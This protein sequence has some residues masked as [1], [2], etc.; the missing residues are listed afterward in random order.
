MIKDELK[1]GMGTQFDPKFAQ[2]MLD[3][4]EEDK[5]FRFRG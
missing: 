2:I 3:I 1:L 4:V 5:D